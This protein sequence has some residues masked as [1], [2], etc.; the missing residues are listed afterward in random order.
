MSGRLQMYQLLSHYIQKHS[1]AVHLLSFHSSCYHLW[2]STFC[3]MRRGCASQVGTIIWFLLYVLPW[4]LA[5]MNPS[6]WAQ[7]VLSSTIYSAVIPHFIWGILRVVRVSKMHDRRALLKS[8]IS[9]GLLTI[10]LLFNPTIPFKPDYGLTIQRAFPLVPFRNAFLPITLPGALPLE[11]P[12]YVYISYILIGGIVIPVM[13]HIYLLYLVAFVTAVYRLCCSC[14]TKKSGDR[15][16]PIE[17]C[18]DTNVD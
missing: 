11:M 14:I 15:D 9:N 16:A 17:S 1:S 6:R 5:A 2:I 18:V 12:L 10:L 8:A 4:A 3:C 13:V 7:I